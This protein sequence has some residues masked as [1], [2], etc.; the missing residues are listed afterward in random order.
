MGPWV[1]LPPELGSVEGSSSSEEATGSGELISWCEGR[2]IR[3][4]LAIGSHGGFA[5]LTCVG[6]NGSK[7]LALGVEALREVSVFGNE[8]EVYDP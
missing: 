7:R 2:C 1:K 4:S 3:I 8:S 6:E 5:V